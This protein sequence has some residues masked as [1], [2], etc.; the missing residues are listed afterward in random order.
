MLSDLDCSEC[1]E[2]RMEP[3]G[4]MQD[5]MSNEEV[6][7]FKLGHEFLAIY[8]IVILWRLNTFHVYCFVSAIFNLKIFKDDKTNK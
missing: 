1:G 4:H 7:V 2:K 5:F 8:S 3:K 6:Q